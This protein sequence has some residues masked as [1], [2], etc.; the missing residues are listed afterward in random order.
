SYTH[1][2]C[3]QAIE[4]R[5]KPRAAATALQA[6]PCSKNF[7]ERSLA[8]VDPPTPV[9][10]IRVRWRAG[11]AGMAWVQLAGGGGLTARPKGGG[12]PP[13]ARGG[14]PRGGSPAHTNQALKGF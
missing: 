2:A 10:A 13:P 12:A 4:E 9:C 5:Q 6:P 7:R 1:E 3:P 8:K 11:S 14:A